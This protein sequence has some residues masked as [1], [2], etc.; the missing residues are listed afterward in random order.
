MPSPRVGTRVRLRRCA[1]C[2]KGFDSGHPAELG[3]AFRTSGFPFEQPARL[4]HPC[5]SIYH[6]Q[7]FYAGAPFTTRLRNNKGLRFPKSADPSLFPNFV[8]EACQVRAALGR[9]LTTTGRDVHLLRLERMRI[10]D[11]MNRLAEGSMQTYKH[12]LRRIL[13]FEQQFGV[14]ILRPTPLTAPSTSACIPLMWAQL[15]HTLRPGKTPGSTV[16][17]SSSRQ[18]RSAVSAYYQWDVAI[19]RPEQAMTSGK[20][21]KSW[22]TPHVLPTDEIGYT[23]FSTGLRR[24][25][26]DV[27][28]KSA[29]LKY[30]HIKFLDDQFR[31]G[32]HT[33]TTRALQ[34]EAAAAGT[35]NLLFWLGW[36]RSNEGFSL[37]RH[38]ID[39]T[40]PALGPR[41]G[42]PQGVGV[43]EIRLLP[44]TKSNSARI[45]DVI[46]AYRCHSGLSLGYWMECLLTFEPADGSSLFST[47]AQRTWTS[48]YFR[49]R[50]VFHH[51]EVLRASNDPSLA[52]FSDLPGERIQ[53]RLYSMHSWRRGADTFVQQHHP[54]VQRR[55]ARLNEIYEHGRWAK[56]HSTSEAMHIH[57]REWDLPE[58]ICLTQLCM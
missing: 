22:I 5:G 4:A 45:A 25:M 35:A 39:I 56:G 54:G 2:L 13:R 42:L 40:P 50:H 48:Q 49:T 8:C 15:D 52:T 57:Y 3:C 32:F 53:D 46:V 20:G 38:D 26:G 31:A 10:L 47:P 28:V 9:E 7:C 24:R 6:T 30:A 21:E 37:T 55:K 34:H 36:L 14:R 58:R 43:V 41:K 17:Y 16:K 18:T 33:A 1:G 29:A 44:E 27:A 11:T 19:S 12:P 23:H 51:L